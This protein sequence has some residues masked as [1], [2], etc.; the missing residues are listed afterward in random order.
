MIRL[1]L[2]GIKSAATPVTTRTL[3]Q[4]VNTLKSGPFRLFS[5]SAAKSESEVSHFAK[6]IIV[7]KYEN[8]K[9]FRLLNIFSISQFLFW[10]YMGH[11]S[12]TSLRD[13]KV[14]G[15]VEQDENASW[16]RKVNLGE[17]KYKY[18]MAGMCFVFGES[19][20][21]IHSCQD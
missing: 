1:L 4:V 13:T 12:F 6:D 14:S 3:P 19:V 21:A 9:F 18:G 15:D 8:P 7:Y 2:T 11:W 16:F 10:G 17:D 5:S 20:V